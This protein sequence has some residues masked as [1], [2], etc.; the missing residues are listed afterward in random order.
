MGMFDAVSLKLA[1]NTE[2]ALIRGIVIGTASVL[3]YLVVVV[4]TT[5]A[6]PPVAA[7]NAAFQI[8]SIIIA[9]MGVG[10]GLQMFLSTYSKGLGCRLDV[11]RKAVGG[12]SGGAAMTGFF[13][14]FSLVPLGCCGTMLYILS[15]LPSVVGSGLA[16][17]L[18]QYSQPLAYVGV[19]IIFVFD[20]ITIYKL[21]KE[22]KTN[23]T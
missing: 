8:N 10:V 22:R 1:H 6:L 5:P 11:K 13:S 17:G 15:L 12:N 14:F 3:A 4:A 16:G 23:T 9:G 7:I 19:A 18:I 20:G 2:R 21:R